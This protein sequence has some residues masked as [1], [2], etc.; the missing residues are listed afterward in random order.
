MNDM[1]LPDYKGGSIV[2]L[3]SSIM[4]ALSCDNA[5]EPL[6]ILPTEELEGYNTIVLLVIDG[7]GYDYLQAYGKGGILCENLRGSMTSV[8]PATTATA[9]T[10]FTTGVAPQQHAITGWF[11]YLKE[12]GVVTTILPFRSRSGGVSLEKMISSDRIF[13][14]EPIFNKIMCDSYYI[15]DAGLVDSSY[16][17]AF[18]GRAQR[19]PH[20]NLDDFLEQMRGCVQKPHKK[21]VYA[22]WSKLDSIS[23]EHGTTSERAFSHFRELHDALDSLVD[24]LEG[25]NTI[26]LV[27]ADH[28]LVDVPP[29]GVIHVKEHPEFLET[30]SLPVCGEPRTAYCYVHPAR[31]GDFEEYVREHFSNVTSFCRSEVLLQKEVY[32]LFEPHPALAD[33]IGDYVMTMDRS[34][35]LRHFIEGEHEYNFIGYHAG[36]TRDE[37]LVPLIVIK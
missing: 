21:Y 13:D 35:V 10:T 14:T 11:V 33:R 29:E 9:V 27:T 6:K 26:L 25:T 31:T 20:H 22:Y 23:H 32:G 17:T 19:V 1:M 30:L 28:G 7:L 34:H 12:I 3:M 16:T 5:Y 24:S 4:R 8:F 37:M 18:A 2:N 15:I 36:T